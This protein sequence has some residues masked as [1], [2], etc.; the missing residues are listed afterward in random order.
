VNEPRRENVVLRIRTALVLYAF[1]ALGLFLLAVPWTPIWDQVVGALLPQGLGDGV[2]SGWVRGAVS[3][4]GVLDLV[5]AAKEARSLWR[6]QRLSG[7][8]P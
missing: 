6:A 3:G 4:L 2:R 5:T 1:G 8:T 7:R